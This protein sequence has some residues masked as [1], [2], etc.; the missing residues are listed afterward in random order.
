MCPFLRVHFLLEVLR[1]KMHKAQGI[2]SA[3][4]E[5]AI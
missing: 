3:G 1:V 5:M 2:I 4:A